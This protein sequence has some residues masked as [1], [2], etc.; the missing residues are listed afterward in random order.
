MTTPKTTNSK[1]ETLFGKQV[2]EFIYIETNRIKEEWH[3]LSDVG[4][5]LTPDIHTYT[6]FLD[7]KYRPEGYLGNLVHITTISPETKQ[8]LFNLWERMFDELKIIDEVS[9]EG[10]DLYTTIITAEN[11]VDVLV[12]E[13]DNDCLVAS[14]IAAKKK[15]DNF[16]EERHDSNGIMCFDIVEAE[17]RRWVTP[18]IVNSKIFSIVRDLWINML[19]IIAYEYTPMVVHMRPFSLNKKVTLMLLYKIGFAQ[20]I[21]SILTSNIREKER[22]GKTTLV[23]NDNLD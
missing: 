13:H 2:L 15:Y 6:S 14:I 19:Q 3:N 23:A 22:A 5:V 4:W 8:I 16:L 17:M 7:K 9:D 18:Q 10:A 20:N 1:L 12:Q 21:V 11:L